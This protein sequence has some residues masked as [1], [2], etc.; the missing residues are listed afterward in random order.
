MKAV[1][2]AVPVDVATASARLKR[3]QADLAELKFKEAARELIPVGEIRQ[4]WSDIL[5]AVR[6]KV[7]ALPSRLRQQIPHLTTIEV[8]LIEAAVRET[9]EDL[10]RSDE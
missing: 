5:S 7:L 9:L 8:A 2:V 10:A 1:E 6:S 4:E 3:W